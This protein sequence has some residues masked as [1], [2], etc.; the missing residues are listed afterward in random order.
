MLRRRRLAAGR[1]KYASWMQSEAPSASLDQ[2]DLED[3]RIGYMIA[4]LPN[5]RNLIA[6]H[7]KRRQQR[8]RKSEQILYDS[9]CRSLHCNGQIPFT[10]MWST[11]LQ[12]L[13]ARNARLS[14]QATSRTRVRSFAVLNNDGRDFKRILLCRDLPMITS[15]CAFNFPMTEIINNHPLPECDTQHNRY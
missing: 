10:V 14:A 1:W 9:D 8:R 12:S 13:R 3:G 4:S 7:G 2:C 11:Y 15:V 5:P 6:L